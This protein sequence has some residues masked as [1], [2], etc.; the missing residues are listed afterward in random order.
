MRFRW[1]A[2]LAA[3]TVCALLAAPASRAQHKY[4]AGDWPYYRGDV[5]GI[6][7]SRLTQINTGNGNDPMS[8]EGKD[9]KQDVAISAGSTVHVFALP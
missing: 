4:G 6:G 3:G 8:Y 2:V 5:E 7:F 1:F 9:G